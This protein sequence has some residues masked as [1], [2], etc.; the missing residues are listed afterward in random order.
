MDFSKNGFKKA[1]YF[2]PV[3]EEL[4]PFIQLL[5]CH[6]SSTIKHNEELVILCIG[7]DKITGD[8]LGPLVGTKLQEQSLPIPVYG[9]LK[10][11]VH[12]VNFTSTLAALRQQ[13]QHPFFLVIDAALGPA[14]KIG[15]VSLSCSPIYPGKGIFRP[16]P[17]VGNISITGI[18]S[19]ADGSAEANLPY[20]RLYL[21][22]KLAAFIS[23]CILTGQF[24]KIEQKKTSR[25][26]MPHKIRRNE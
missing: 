12:A 21:V 23:K 8:C 2:F 14:D 10:H 16:L 6:I 13:Y 22:D 24:E 18:I 17:P 3:K 9:T 19:E 26:I 4:P 7:T 25:F 5:S 1:H 11:P 15:C 20:T